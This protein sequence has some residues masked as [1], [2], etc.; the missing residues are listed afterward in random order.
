LKNFVERAL[1]SAHDLDKSHGG[2]EDAERS[3]L[4]D[5]PL[6]RH[7]L[8]YHP[9]CRL[10]V[11]IHFGDLEPQ[12]VDAK[13]AHGHVGGEVGEIFSEQSLRV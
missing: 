9:T 1:R 13:I 10:P 12:L 4:L 11:I 3:T 2:E 7:Q 8:P 6:R 5:T